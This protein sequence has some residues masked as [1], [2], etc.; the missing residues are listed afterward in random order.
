[1]RASEADILIIPGFRGSEPEH[2]QSRWEFQLP[3][4][5]RVPQEDWDRPNL[6]A[7]RSRIAQ[8]VERAE[9]P[10]ILVAHSL[11]VLAA[12]HAAPL[13]AGGKVKGAFLVAPPSAAGLLTLDELDP[14]FL[15]CPGGPLAFPA[16]LIASRNDSYSS[17][18]D[19]A[20]LA[21]L[22]GAKLVDAGFSGHINT[23]S[24]HGPWPEGLMC[25][26]AF[27]KTLSVI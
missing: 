26:A 14:A 11:G 25:F 18:E 15:T 21:K 4:A 6:A 16:L 24:G 5:R 3:T 7:W 2:W 17:L 19:S 20:A 8:E 10:V 22:L 1:M 23:E 12:A 27:L 13:F 9:R